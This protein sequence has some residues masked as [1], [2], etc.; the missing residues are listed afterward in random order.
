[1]AAAAL[2]WPFC[3]NEDTRPYETSNGKKR[4]ACNNPE[5]PHNPF[6]AD[7]RYNGCAPDV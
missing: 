2:E 6:Y 5:R 1:M 3:G 4:Y 7:C